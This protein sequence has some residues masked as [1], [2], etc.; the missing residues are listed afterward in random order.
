MNDSPLEQQR[1]G[2][3]LAALRAAL[4]KLETPPLDETAVRAAFRTARAAA[5]HPAL[6]PHKTARLALAAAAA[7][8]LAA[9]G[10][11]GIVSLGGDDAAP[12]LTAAAPAA[13][14]SPAATV[15]A[16]QPLQNSSGLM[17]SASYSVVRVRIPLASLVL[18]P[19]TEEDGTIEAELL[20]GEDGLARGI[21]FLQ[22]DALL[23]S[24]QD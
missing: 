5:A 3:E 9:V 15:V 8:A 10:A 18:V 7:L 19:G 24:A 4:G 16:F 14:P 21:R 11:L 17:P 23:V 12:A 20:V 22:S 13:P 6:K 2:A 1:Q